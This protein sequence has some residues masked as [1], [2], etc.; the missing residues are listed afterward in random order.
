MLEEFKQGIHLS[1][2]DKIL[3]TDRYIKYIRDMN[4]SK[5]FQLGFFSGTIAVYNFLKNSKMNR[6]PKIIY[7]IN[8]FVCIHTFVYEM[9]SKMYTNKKIVYEMDK[10][11]EK[12]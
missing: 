7:S 9:Y 6:I 4:E 12:I 8:L 1:K 5:A 11:L 2:Q 3:N 10:L